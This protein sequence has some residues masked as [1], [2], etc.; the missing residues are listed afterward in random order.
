M[1]RPPI[2]AFEAVRKYCEKNVTCDG[3]PLK[4]NQK[5]VGDWCSIRPCYWKTLEK[6]GDEK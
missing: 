6:E 2:K 1:S 5:C 3:C 4:S